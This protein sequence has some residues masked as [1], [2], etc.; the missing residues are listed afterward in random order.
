MRV[1]ITRSPAPEAR[2][3]RAEEVA[4]PVAEPIE[5]YVPKLRLGGL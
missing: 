4:A 3:E 2:F 1:L 5:F